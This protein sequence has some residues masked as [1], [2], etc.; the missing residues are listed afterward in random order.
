MK[1][2]VGW[3]CFENKLL[4]GWPKIVILKGKVFNIG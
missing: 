2:K 1:T 3:S 4:K